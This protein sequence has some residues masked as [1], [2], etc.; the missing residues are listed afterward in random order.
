MASRTHYE[1]WLAGWYAQNKTGEKGQKK[2]NQDVEDG[3]E[4]PVRYI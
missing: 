3:D 1:A 2:V 4:E